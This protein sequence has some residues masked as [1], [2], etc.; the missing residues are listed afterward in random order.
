MDLLL[1]LLSPLGSCKAHVKDMLMAETYLV[2]EQHEVLAI[3][4]LLL[5]MPGAVECFH[6]SSHR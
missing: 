5:R 3:V 6:F 1:S 4:C 2:H